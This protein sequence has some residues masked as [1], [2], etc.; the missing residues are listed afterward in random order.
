VHRATP[1]RGD[2]QGR[3]VGAL[4][5]IRIDSHFTAAMDAKNSFTKTVY[6]SEQIALGACRPAACLMH[7]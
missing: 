4:A 1:A 5:H 3:A 6:H 7:G 2:E